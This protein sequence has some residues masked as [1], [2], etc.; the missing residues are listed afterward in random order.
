MLRRSLMILYVSCLSVLTSSC[1]GGSGDNNP[2]TTTPETG[3]LLDSPVSGVKYETASQSGMTDTQ[4]QYSYLLGET[5]T[6][7]IG[8]IVFPST[9]AASVVTPLD[10]VGKTDLTDTSVINI[11][12][13]LQSLD[14]DGDPANGIEIS[15]TAQSAATGL[16]VDFESST[17]DT[18][19][20]NLV[21]NSGSVTSALIDQTTA[22][23][24]FKSTLKAQ[25]VDLASYFNHADNRQWNYT[26]L[27]G[28]IPGGM[29]EYTVF[30]VVNRQDVFIHGWDP[31]WD[32]DDT[33]DYF[34]RDMS[35]GLFFIGTQVNGVDTIFDPPIKSCDSFYESCNEAGI[36]AIFGAYDFT[37]YTEL[38]TVSLT[39]GKTYNDCMKSTQTDNISG[40]VRVDWY[41]RGVGKVKEDKVG[42]FI[43]ELESITT[44]N[45]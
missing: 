44:Y 27:S 6:F 21:A 17:F 34:L 24:H 3:V 40:Q 12:R 7:S 5:V 9:K 45:P 35:N 1:G 23:D 30:G 39:S 8:D 32:S 26:F 41:C 42:D 28:G 13:L 14:V 2:S 11:L 25:P 33:K 10:M 36:H 4:G 37:Y 20:A 18:D 38:A 43:F 22:I 19:V 29:Y 31:N 16:T 15:A